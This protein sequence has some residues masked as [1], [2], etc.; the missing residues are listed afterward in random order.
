MEIKIII[1]ENPINS[2]HPAKSYLLIEEISKGK[3][4]QI[5]YEDLENYKKFIEQQGNMRI[6]LQAKKLETKIF[7]K[8]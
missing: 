1:E 5:N 7:L 6:Q 2:F 8:D 4:V 3:S